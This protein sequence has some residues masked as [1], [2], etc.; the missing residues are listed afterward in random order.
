MLQQSLLSSFRASEGSAGGLPQ[1]KKQSA[2]D[3]KDAS[4][5]I[6]DKEMISQSLNIG[7][8]LNQSLSN[9]LNRSN[10]HDY[11]YKKRINFLRNNLESVN[12]MATTGSIREQTEENKVKRIWELWG[13]DQ[14]KPSVSEL[15]EMMKE[16]HPRNSGAEFNKFLERLEMS[17]K[18]EASP[19]GIGVYRYDNQFGAQ[20]QLAPGAQL[21]SALT[22]TLSGTQR[23]STL[24]REQLEP[25]MSLMNTPES[26][27]GKKSPEPR[28]LPR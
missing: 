21:Q 18:A 28:I 8:T 5:S 13:S 7:L 27:R 24:S 17:K 14:E 4:Q 22:G 2:E 9:L 26:P 10:T 1:I 12:P 20:Q 3:A 25:T 6:Q 11:V 23:Y 19:P 16:R 15:V